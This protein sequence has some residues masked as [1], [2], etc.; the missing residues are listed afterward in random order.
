MEEHPFLT[1]VGSGVAANALFV[2][3][4][5]INRCFQKRWKHSECEAPCCRCAAD[6]ENTQRGELNLENVV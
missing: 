4:Y 1:N 6:I 2:L 5:I 3:L